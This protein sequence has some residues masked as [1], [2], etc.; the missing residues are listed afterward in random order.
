[1]ARVCS[2]LLVV[3]HGASATLGYAYGGAN[4]QASQC[5]ISSVGT[6]NTVADAYTCC[7]VA[8][9]ALNIAPNSALN[10]P[11]DGVSVPTQAFDWAPKGCFKRFNQLYYNAH[12]TGTARNDAYPVCRVPFPPPS[13]P[14]PSP[15]YSP[16]EPPSPPAPPTPPP[17]PHPPP[18]MSVR[19]GCKRF[20]N[21]ASADT[22][23]LCIKRNADPWVE[24]TCVPGPNCPGNDFSQCAWSGVT[25]C[26]DEAGIWKD[27]KC[28]KKKRKGKCRKQ[29][30]L[31]KCRLTCGGCRRE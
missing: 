19:C 6:G 31:E 26:N 21:G 17:N 27:K 24:G 25:Q 13:P 8:A 23:N 1:M 18:P 9:A 29:R 16:P 5:P 22:E 4:T 2:L 20:A 10:C 14:P 3:T 30:V 7:V 12:A 15:P 28:A 11:S